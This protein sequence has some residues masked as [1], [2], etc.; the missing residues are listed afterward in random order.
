LLNQKHQPAEKHNNLRDECSDFVKNSLISFIENAK[1]FHGQSESVARI[2][3]S[4]I[5]IA[6]EFLS[7]RII[8]E[9]KMLE[10]GNEIVDEDAE[11]DKLKE[12]AE[13]QLLSDVMKRCNYFVTIQNAE[14]QVK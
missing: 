13:G 14:T 7:S 9:N 3:T 6:E 4:N 5:N 11:N 12:S 2:D 8:E 1:K 10:D